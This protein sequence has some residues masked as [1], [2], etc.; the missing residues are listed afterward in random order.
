MTNNN[1]NENEQ[2]NDDKIRERIRK[3]YQLVEQGIGGG[4]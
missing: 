1:I 2:N 3:L 4:E